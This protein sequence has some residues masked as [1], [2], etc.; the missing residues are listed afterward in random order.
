MKRV[1]AVLTVLDGGIGG[2][3]S[4]RGGVT[5]VSVVLVHSRSSRRFHNHRTRVYLRILIKVQFENVQ[6]I[7]K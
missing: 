2:S 5:A 7:N 3:G 1:I 4:G 6:L